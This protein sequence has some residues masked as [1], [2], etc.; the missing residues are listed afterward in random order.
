MSLFRLRKLGSGGGTIPASINAPIQGTDLTAVW[1]LQFSG[2]GPS[3][4]PTNGTWA[5]SIDAYLSSFSASIDG[6]GYLYFPVGTT[7]VTISNYDFSTSP[8][9]HMSGSSPGNLIFL[10]C[11][12]PK[13]NGS[14][15]V[16]VYN[17]AGNPDFATGTVLLTL[18]RCLLDTTVYSVNSG[19]ILL[20]H[21]RVT[22][23][24]QGIGQVQV[25][26]TGAATVTITDSYITGGGINAAVGAH[27]ELMQ[28][29]RDPSIFASCFWNLTR[30]VVDI[31]K[32]GQA[33][34]ANP[35]LWTAVWSVTD[36]HSTYTDSIMIGAAQ[37]IANPNGNHMGA[38]PWHYYGQ[39]SPS[40]SIT[41][42]VF[43]TAIGICRNADGGA[44]R[45][46]DGGGN[47]SFA[48]NAAI[49]SAD[50]A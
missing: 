11:I 43:D 27:I 13:S 31:S 18:R 10:D 29:A 39:G 34:T 24:I 19:P 23:Q 40:G 25:G 7:T 9:I 45:P 17:S 36:C 28:F 8:S 47:R 5:G 16:P 41:N 44:A 46:S 14:V 6:Q 3:S 48:T 26:G 15:G 21:C 32:D 12:M 35:A 22:N 2:T 49:T 42:C 1:N 50:F 4:G 30:T 37:M 33:T 38:N 20:D